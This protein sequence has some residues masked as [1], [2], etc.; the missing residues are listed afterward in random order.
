M[1]KKELELEL[2]DAEAI[3]QGLVVTTTLDVKMQDAA[4]DA[5]NDSFV[6]SGIKPSGALVAMD[7]ET[8]GIRA[9]VGGKNYAKSQLNLATGQGRQPGSTFKPFALAAWIDQ[10]KSPESY[11]DGPSEIEFSVEEINEKLDR[12]AA[13]EPW[14][15]SNY[16][17]ADY[18]ELS[19]REATWKSVNTVYAQLVLEVDPVHMRD[20]AEAAGIQRELSAV[21]SL[22]LGTSEVTPVEMTRAY[23]TFATGGTRH[24]AHTVEEIRRDGDTIFKASTRGEEDALAIE[25]HDSRQVAL[26]VT[27]VLRGVI[28]Q[29]TGVAANIG[30][31]AAGKTGTTQSHGDAWFVGYTPQITA[32]VWMGNV[33][34]NEPMEG[35]YTGGSVPA[36]TWAAFM[37]EAMKDME[38]EDFPAPSL[39]D[40]EITRPAPPSETPCGRGE[41]RSEPS[42]G[43][44]ES[45]CVPKPE[46][47]EAPV[48]EA[49][50][51][52]TEKPE[53][54][55]EPTEAPPPPP[56]SP[57]PTEAVSPTPKPTKKPAPEPTD[58]AGAGGGGGAGG[59]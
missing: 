42:D 45:V 3:Y 29:G 12:E 19:L 44:S 22:V 34:N 31:P 2:E 57:E 5:Y 32:T 11:F 10:G 17:E 53:P 56:P 28:E 4:E 6:E 37:S 58:G 46:K 51:E 15:V 24:K 27:D 14:P 33:G 40:L 54:S 8:G 41:T 20:M 9:L 18:G 47:S 16:E 38:V 48:T 43:S 13:Q 7:N 25:G 1:V 49:P 59:G 23:A 30:R 26:T 21:P 39:D 52:P 36:A 55:P 50:P 35:E